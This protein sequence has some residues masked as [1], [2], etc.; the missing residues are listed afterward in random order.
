M[1]TR[2]GFPFLHT[3][4]LPT[5][6]VDFPFCKLHVTDETRDIIRKFHQLVTRVEKSRSKKFGCSLRRI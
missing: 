2:S 5:D 3:S 6:Q 1:K 4:D